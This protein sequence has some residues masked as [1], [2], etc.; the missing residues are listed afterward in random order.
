MPIVYKI[1]NHYT[2]KCYI[3]WTGLTLEKRWG[4]HLAEAS[5][6]KD[7]R[8]FYNAIR[9]H[10]VDCWKAEVLLEVPTKEDAKNKEIEFIVEHNSYYEG[11]NATKGG[12]GNN[13]IIMSEESNQARSAALKGVKKSDSTIEKFRKRKSTPE[14]NYKRSIAHTGMSKPWVKWTKEQVNKRAMTQ[15]GLSL[16]QYT[17]IHELRKQGLLIREI[18]EQVNLSNDMVKKWL[19]KSWEL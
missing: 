7:N 10:G 2:G 13:G 5:K 11:Y 4:Q 6:N 18:S 1:T 19:K 12:D 3:G 15:R 17:Q 14:E 8:K 9:K 16:E